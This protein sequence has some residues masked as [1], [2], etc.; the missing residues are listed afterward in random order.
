M[1]TTV[2]R[3]VNPSSVGGD[4]TTNGLSGATAAYK[5]ITTALTTEYNGGAG[6]YANLIATD[7]ILQFV[8]EGGGDRLNSVYIMPNFT[9][10]EFRYIWIYCAPDKG[11]VG[12][13]DST[14]YF[15]GFNGNTSRIFAVDSSLRVF[16]FDGIQIENPSTNGVWT[17]ISATTTTAGSIWT[18]DRCIFR[19]TGSS[20][21]QNG[22]CIAQ[23]STTAKAIRLTNSIIY[24]KFGFAVR[25]Q[26]ANAQSSASYCYNNTIFSAS[27]G[28][29]LDQAASPSTKCRVKNNII[30]GSSTH[31]YQLDA[32]A[33]STANISHDATSPQ[34]A[35]RNMV[36]LFVDEPNRNF[37]LSPSDTVAL[38]QGTDLS[39]DAYPITTDITTATRGLPW[40][41]GAFAYFAFGHPAKI[42]GSFGYKFIGRNVLPLPDRSQARLKS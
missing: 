22:D 37:H 6:T 5:S 20:V 21:N 32:G 36:P 42:G 8:C 18:F 15:I 27:T 4:G 34:T 14:K 28:L 11:H 17:I 29:G 3:Y 40:D 26:F 23:A 41:I 13:W 10:D 38:G 25:S 33:V 1:T 16:K 9:T 31:D 24:G 19:A 39:G 35:L 12:V 2:I 30:S 7:V